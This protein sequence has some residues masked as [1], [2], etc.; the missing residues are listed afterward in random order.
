MGS[1]DLIITTSTSDKE[2]VW[3]CDCASVKRHGRGVVFAIREAH[4]VLLGECEAQS[5]SEK[6]TETECGAQSEMEK[7]RR[8]E[9]E[10]RKKE[11]RT[12]L[13]LSNLSTRSPWPW[14]G[15]SINIILPAR[16]GSY[17]PLGEVLVEA[18][19]N[20]T[21]VLQ[22]QQQQPRYHRGQQHSVQ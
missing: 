12:A 15:G 6:H 18:M 5:E 3:V 16:R 19:F 17:L 9:R 22:R 4:C 21:D 2:S 8:K 11:Q 13:M 14:C 1:F 20:A 10:R 7:R